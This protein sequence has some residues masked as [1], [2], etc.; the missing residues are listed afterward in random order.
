MNKLLCAFLL[1]TGLP[2]TSV[3]AAV[4]ETHDGAFFL[5]TVVLAE[6]KPAKVYADLLRVSR[7]WHSEH[8]WSKSARNLKLEGRAG[9]CF[10]EKLA[11]GG[12]VEHGHVI[13]ARPGQLL[14][15]DAA[16][17]PLQDTAVKGVLS[18]SLAPDGGGTRITMTYK[19]AGA[20]PLDAAKL[21][22]MV[23][24]VMSM[25]LNRLRDYASGRPLK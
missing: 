10:C 9:G 24:Q 25:Q 13:F 14:R 12:S 17:G 5:E 22:P 20:L 23:D 2:V 21:A 3:Q 16:L 8:T 6:A 4:K 18:F 1:V 11:D 7:W 15:I 19:V